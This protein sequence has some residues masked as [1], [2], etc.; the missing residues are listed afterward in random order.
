[1]KSNNRGN[2][3]LTMI[4]HIILLLISFCFIININGDEE[5]Y[6]WDPDIYPNLTSDL[7]AKFCTGSF[8]NPPSSI[9]DPDQILHK[10]EAL[11]LD[12]LINNERN[13]T[14]CICDACPPSRRGLNIKVALVKFVRVIRNITI[15]RSV[16]MFAERTRRKW[17]FGEDCSNDVLIFFA[18][19]DDKVYV[20]MGSRARSVISDA[21]LDKVLSETKIHFTSRYY[22]QGLESIIASFQDLCLDYEPKPDRLGLGSIVL[23]VLCIGIALFIVF[24]AIFWFCIRRHNNSKRNSFEFF[25]S[26]G[27]N[28][29]K[30]KAQSQP[31][32]SDPIYKPV[33]T[34]EKPDIG[35][36]P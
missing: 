33:N 3:S 9:C 20:S 22:K 10:T 13:D 17:R 4:S 19:L 32:I 35:D 15:D 1:M 27:R 8:R 7:Q 28:R 30:A 24:F 34:T 26:W 11:F 14:K 12:E 29:N 36:Q 16:E 2:H 31:N 25:G 21:D 23:I 6:N 5:V 18:A